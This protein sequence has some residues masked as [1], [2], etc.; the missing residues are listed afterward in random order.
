M[1]WFANKLDR[2]IGHCL[3]GR[4]VQGSIVL[5]ALYNKGTEGPINR[6]TAPMAII[7][8]SSSEQNQKIFIFILIWILSTTSAPYGT[9]CIAK[10][11]TL[12][13]HRL[14]VM[15]IRTHIE[16]ST[17]SVQKVWHRTEHTA[18]LRPQTLTMTWSSVHEHLDYLCHQH[19]S[20]GL[21]QL[22]PLHST[23]LH[24]KACPKKPATIYEGLHAPGT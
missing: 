11:M 21:N 5:S 20:N 9:Q 24:T 22:W 13:N 6:S 8:S 7:S 23:G 10:Y 12:V 19:C 17:F 15:H 1:F 16:P 14:C 2:N 3:E 18:H 4:A